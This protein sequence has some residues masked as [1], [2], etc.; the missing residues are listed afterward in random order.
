MKQGYE[1]IALAWIMLAAP[2][3]VIPVATCL[4]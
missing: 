2:F 1:G 4:F 3:T